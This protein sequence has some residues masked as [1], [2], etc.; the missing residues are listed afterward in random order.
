MNKIPIYH[1]HIVALVRK[2]SIRISDIVVT[3]PELYIERVA[4]PG[5]NTPEINPWKK[6]K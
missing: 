3:L 2:Q 6:I 1:L 5:K 4:T